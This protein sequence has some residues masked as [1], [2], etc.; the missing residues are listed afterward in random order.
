[1]GKEMGNKA[2][3]TP[4]ACPCGL[5]LPYRECCGRYIDGDTPAPDAERLM[6]SRYSAYALGREAYLLATWHPD[7]RPPV[8]HLEGKLKPKWLGLQVLDHRQQDADH[9]TVAFV[10][11]YKLGGLA[12]KMRETSRFVRVTGRWYYLDGQVP[13]GG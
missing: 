5:P 1:M 4:E 3:V 7:T 6:R 12:L 11:R 9:A 8:G 2:S 13:E 10:A